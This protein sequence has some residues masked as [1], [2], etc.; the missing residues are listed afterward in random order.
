MRGRGRR[1]ALRRGT[2]PFG[3]LDRSLTRLCVHATPNANGSNPLSRRWSRRRRGSRAS[4]ELVGV[5]LCSGHRPIHRVDR[6][7]GSPPRLRPVRTSDG[8][9][10]SLPGSVSSGVMARCGRW[11]PAHVTLVSGRAG[12]HDEPGGCR[13]TYG[14]MCPALLVAS[15]VRVRMSRENMNL[16][17]VARQE[18]CN[19]LGLRWRWH[20]CWS[21]HWKVQCWWRAPSKTSPAFSPS[22][23]DS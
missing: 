6:C 7:A 22:P 8:D 20:V 13:R 23:I 1:S 16:S 9:Q 12:Q 15:S 10:D 4:V 2:Q 11:E 19:S 21:V 17:R 5:L 3:C 18:S 14:A